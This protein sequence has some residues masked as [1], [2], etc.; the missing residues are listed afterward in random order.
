MFASVNY[1]DYA[2]NVIVIVQA[3]SNGVYYL[4]FRNGS[5]GY[6]TGGYSVNISYTEIGSEERLCTH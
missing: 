6:I 4:Y 1:G 5:G 3:K 2:M